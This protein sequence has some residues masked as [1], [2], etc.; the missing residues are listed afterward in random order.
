VE[1]F[2]RLIWQYVRELNASGSED[3]QRV[4]TAIREAH[5]KRIRGV[6]ERQ[7]RQRRERIVLNNARRSGIALARLIGNE[8]LNSAELEQAKDE[9]VRALNFPALKKQ[10]ELDQALLDESTKQQ[11]AEIRRFQAEE[12][13]RRKAEKAAKEA[14][15]RRLQAEEEFRRRAERAK[16]ARQ[17]ELERDAFR[18]ELERRFSVN[19]LEAEEFFQNTGS[20]WITKQE[21][22]QKKLAFVRAWLTHNLPEDNIQPD[23]EQLAA[24]AAVGGHVQ[25]VARAGS[26]KTTMSVT[27][28]FFLVRHCKVPADQILMLAFNR[29]AAREIRKKLLYLFSPSAETEVKSELVR[30]LAR[31]K[32]P[33]SDEKED[34][35]AEVVNTVAANRAITLPYAMTFHALAYAIVH[36]EMILFDD[37]EGETLALSRVFQQV[38]DDHLQVPAFKQ[39]IRKVMLAHF[40][41]D[42]DRIIQGGYDR[43]KS[44]FLDLRR[45][46][47]RES[48]GGEYVKSYGEK[49]IADF[50]FEHD[51]PYKYERNYWWNG[52][53]YRPDFTIFLTPESGV[54]VEYFGLAGDP[55]YDEM[56]KQKRAY[57]SNEQD[58]KLVE[59]SPSDINPARPRRFLNQ[60]KIQL[61]E[62]G[63]ICNKLSE[64][65]IWY[66]VSDRAIDTFTKSAVTFLGRCRKS[67]LS[68]EELDARIS[69]HIAVSD[70]EQ[71]YLG[72]MRHLYGAYLRRL[73]AT[74]EDDFDGLMQLAAAEIRGGQTV[75]RRTAGSGDLRA[76]RHI[77]VDEFQDFSD[78]FYRMLKAIQAQNADAELFCVGDDWQ[79]INGFAGSDLKF[80]R[81]FEEY[82]GKARSLSISTNYRSS[83]AIVSVGNLLMDGKGE[84]AA[85]HKQ[86]PGSVLLANLNSFVPSTIEKER[87]SG[88]V[89]TPAVLRIAN[90]ASSVGK[91]LVVLSRRTGVPWFVNYPEDSARRGVSDYLDAAIPFLPRELLNTLESSTVHKYKG[92]EKPIVIVADCVARSYPLIHPNWIF[93]R[94][95]GDSLEEAVDAERRL[96]YVGLT[97][98]EETLVIFTDQ[99]AKSPFLEEVERKEPISAIDWGRFPPFESSAPRLIVKVGNQSANGT[100]P[101]YEIKDVLKA[102]GFSW[103]ST[104]WTGWTKSYPAKSLSIDS[105]KQEIWVRQGDGIEIQIYDEQ[106]NLLAKYTVDHGH[107]KC[108]FDRLDAVVDR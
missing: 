85:A 103:Q 11:R 41:E 39:Q 60:L 7:D 21:F 1:E 102:S 83:K 6:N 90:Y 18:D 34:A 45:S 93:T 80:F 57:W 8:N 69:A 98:A 32:K 50:L 26:G 84:P 44:E 79:A 75:F 53:N 61:E 49:L 25:V 97:R 27:R 89:F 37:Q 33:T 5:A 30:K 40:R 88:D 47:P 95:F 56:S 87:H 77:F 38:I 24:I 73:A 29:K 51:V 13:S 100:A 19:F 46:L 55:D 101:T 76:L 42:W 48:L 20:G 92:L 36:P 2:E 59:F 68:A 72:I 70:V 17:V 86:A 81:K 31:K 108:V 65:E 9:M 14:E 35:Q 43:S 63:I 4:V 82:F 22:E 67:S 105:L 94:I 16:F 10:R 71:G 99:N 104:G 12:E 23:G 106:N 96:L 15:I 107:W 54:I 64:E 28:A 66:R 91:S 78:L 62:L 52:I 58:W 3:L 74:G